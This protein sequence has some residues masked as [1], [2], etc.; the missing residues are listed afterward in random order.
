MEVNIDTELEA[1]P[2]L[3]LSDDKVIKDGNLHKLKYISET[4]LL[5]NFGN[6]DD[7][8]FG[9][10]VGDRFT[11]LGKVNLQRSTAEILVLEYFNETN[12]NRI[13]LDQ[14]Y[15]LQSKKNK[16]SFIRRKNAM[17]RIL[18]GQSVISNL[19]DYFDRDAI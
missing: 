5:E 6:D 10:I 9:I 16:S 1:L 4:A 11:S 3:E 17:D 12:K 14:E 13:K 18:E 15:T 19:L 7:V 8:R 2:I